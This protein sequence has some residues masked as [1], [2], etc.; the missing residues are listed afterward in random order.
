MS[1][2]ID[3][4]KVNEKI[5]DG[6]LAKF[7]I[8]TKGGLNAKVNALEKYQSS[9]ADGGHVAPD[10]VSTPCTNCGAESDFNLPECPFCGDTDADD[11]E[12][13]NAVVASELAS[14]PGN[15]VPEVPDDEPE[16]RA[17]GGSNRPPAIETEGATVD[18]EQEAT[19]E[20]EPVKKK[21][22]QK[23]SR[24]IGKAIAPSVELVPTKDLDDAVER[25]QD[26]LRS[27]A[28]S[29]WELGV[30]LL[31]LWDKGLWKQR[32]VAGK[33]KYTSW[34]LFCRDELHMS[35]ANTFSIMD[36][37]KAFSKKDFEELGHSKLTLLLRLPKSRQ[38]ELAEEARKGRLPRAR[39]K[40]ILTEEVPSGQRRDTGRTKRGAGASAP[41]KVAERKAARAAL[42][43]D[44]EITAVSQLG[45]TKLKL[46]ARP[47]AKKPGEKP[48]RAMSV[49]QD[50]WCEEELVNGVLVKYV[51][52]KTATGL[53]LI[54]ERKRPPAS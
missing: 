24:V 9:T 21:K 14:G 38:L 26:A 42:K 11:V 29:Y 53:E 19:H 5:I 45:R 41:A 2:K 51:I 16:S 54:I 22:I 13:P 3:I 30:A 12:D 7:E 49:T 46:W 23:L 52:M 47:N 32:T 37:A 40:E 44:G 6:Y 1:L 10:S 36:A 43:P 27:G 20:H 33:Q 39:L 17:G 31:D 8:T 35:H 15:V 25:V 34:N 4:T 28:S 18:A 50:P 48:G